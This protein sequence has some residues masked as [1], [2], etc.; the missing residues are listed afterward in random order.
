MIVKVN[1]VINKN[2]I[3]QL[4]SQGVDIIGISLKLTDE[5]SDPR[6]L[7]INDIQNIQ[8]EVLIPYL[9]LNLNISE[10][11]KE[12]IVEVAQTIKPN[13]L[14]LFIEANSIRDLKELN[15]EHLSTIRAINETEMDVISFGN[16]IGY[17]GPSSIPDSLG[18]YKNLKYQEVNIDTLG[19]KSQQRIK[20]REEWSELLNIQKI[21][22]STLGD[23]ILESITESMQDRPYLVD[24]RNID[25]VSVE[26][27]IEIGAKGITMS[28]SSINE[29]EYLNN[30]PNSNHIATMLKLTKILE[31]TKRIK[32][33]GS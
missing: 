29:D 17:D 32:E 18:I 4:L 26:K 8:S 12:D 1:R 21:E 9:S 23:T 15:E 6:A 22:Q 31:I 10:Y 5:N 28:L 14:N 11:R 3:L 27:L 7:C 25:T 30:L 20:N 16:G 24:D 19:S 13:S 2:E 33:Y